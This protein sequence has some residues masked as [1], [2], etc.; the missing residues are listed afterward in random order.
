[1]KYSCEQVG[2]PEYTMIDLGTVEALSYHVQHVCFNTDT[3]IR[4]CIKHGPQ[5]T[6]T[7]TGITNKHAISPYSGITTVGKL[8]QYQIGALS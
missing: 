2:I 1:M 4:M 3:G 5:Y 8:S 6:M 7:A